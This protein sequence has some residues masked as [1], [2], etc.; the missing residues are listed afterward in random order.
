MN[1]KAEEFDRGYNAILSLKPGRRL[2]FG[3]E[4]GGAAPTNYEV[5]RVPGGWLYSLIC[6]GTGVAMC[7]AAEKKT[8]MET[9]E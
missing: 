1:R 2:V 5:V 7:F 3:P 6:P 8:E 4:S 9:K